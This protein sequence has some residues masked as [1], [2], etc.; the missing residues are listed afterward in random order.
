MGSSSDICD[1]VFFGSIKS[2]HHFSLHWKGQSLDYC[3][4]RS[5]IIWEDRRVV[6][7]SRVNHHIHSRII[8]FLPFRLHI[9]FVTGSNKFFNLTGSNK[10]FNL[11]T[12]SS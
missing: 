8:S 1:R 12:E 5:I 10:F 3:I 4:L 9:A 11:Y 6:F 2:F 7:K